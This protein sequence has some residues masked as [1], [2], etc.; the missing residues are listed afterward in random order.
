MFDVEHAQAALQQLTHAE[1]THQKWY[2]ALIRG[3]VCHLPHDDRDV[4]SDAHR[5]CRF[6]RWYYEEAPEELRAHPLF[7]AL[8]A[9]HE[10]MHRLTAQLLRASE[11]KFAV[12]LGAYDAFSSAQESFRGKLTALKSDIQNALHGH[13]PLTGAESRISMV[14]ALR[15][16][17]EL[18]KRHVGQCCVAVMDL[19]QF[20]A[21]NDT[22]GHHVGD[23][24]LV[25]TVRR[26]AEHMRPYD[27]VF[28]YGGDEFLVVMPTTDLPAARAVIERIRDGLA[29][30]TIA[31]GGHEPISITASF[32]V[33]VL[34]PS[35]SVADSVD[36]ADNAMYAAKAGG[37]NRVC[38]WE[39]ATPDIR[40]NSPARRELR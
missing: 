36:R 31:L 38:V 18:A 30:T 21:I 12:P 11:S 14:A 37:R 4:A 10:R 33:T 28:R 16:A 6:G 19:D 32:G 15:D 1:D 7:R 9:E 34:D 26:I 40:L 8:E 20:K 27:K 29:S 2:R 35:I 23:Q 13:D 24:V 5:R 3:I 25:T 22:Y 17:L 39:R